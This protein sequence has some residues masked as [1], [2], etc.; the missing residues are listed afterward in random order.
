MHKILKIFISIEF[1]LIILISIVLLFIGVAEMLIIQLDFNIINMPV[2]FY[3]NMIIILGFIGLVFL[4][5]LYILDWSGHD[6]ILDFLNGII[7]F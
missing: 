4:F 7:N 2:D 5:Y 3:Y 6:N 1:Q